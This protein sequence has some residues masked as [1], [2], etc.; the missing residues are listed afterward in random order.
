MGKGLKCGLMVLVIQ[1]SGNIIKL[2]AKV[3]FGT[4]MV[5]NTRVTGLMTKPKVL[6]FILM[7]MEPNIRVN[8][9]KI[10]SMGGASK[11]GLMEAAMR[12]RTI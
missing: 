6:V 1:A 11:H 7:P 9:G 8:G 5:I 4:C 2:V 12:A 3:L 10:Y